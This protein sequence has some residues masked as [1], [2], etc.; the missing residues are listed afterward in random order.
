MI[1]E[2]IPLSMIVLASLLAVI[3]FH[4]VR[5][6]IKSRKVHTLPVGKIRNTTDGYSLI[7]TKE[8]DGCSGCHF[9]CI[10]SDDMNVVNRKVFGR[11]SKAQRRDK[12]GVIF[13][14]MN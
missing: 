2:N 5:S 1:L 10:D 13:K 11:C 3:T 6:I 9:N 8:I 4:I 7:V 14:Q 12:Q